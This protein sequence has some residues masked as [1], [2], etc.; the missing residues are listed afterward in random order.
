MKLLPKL[1]PTNLLQLFFIFFMPLSLINDFN[2]LRYAVQGL[3][4]LNKTA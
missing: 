4:A 3:P 2:D 1:L